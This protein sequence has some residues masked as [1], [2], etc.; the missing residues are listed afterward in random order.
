VGSQYEFFDH[1]LQTAA[2]T[3]GDMADDLRGAIGRD[4]FSLLYQPQIDPSPRRPVSSSRSGSGSFV[5]PA[6]TSRV[7]R[8]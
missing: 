3:K 7:T 6:R 4:E 8:W 2:R 5:A 1:E